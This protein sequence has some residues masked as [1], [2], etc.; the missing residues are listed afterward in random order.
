MPKI[1]VTGA[2]GQIGSELVPALRAAHGV[3]NV[4]ASDI[5]MP[6]GP[7]LGDGAPFVQLDSTDVQHLHD[8][9]RK[10]EVATIYHLSAL[11][12]AVAEER[13][14]TAW[15]VNM[16]SLYGVLEVA[17]NDGCA[18]FFPSSIGAFGPTT[19]PDR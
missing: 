10:Y 1:L 7:V 19:P 14:Q 17:R 11:L 9:V 16:G 18:V 3:E 12:S 15:Q 6:T 8:T 5:R 2:L 4:I 13:P